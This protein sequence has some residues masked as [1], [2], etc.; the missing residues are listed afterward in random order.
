MMLS[1]KAIRGLYSVFS[2]ALI[3]L[4]ALGC[5]SA[6]QGD[7]LRSVQA[8]E[9]MGVEACPEGYNII[10]GTEGDDVIEGT[11]KP[12]CIVAYGGDD[13]IMAGNGCDI[14]YAGAGNDWI[15]TGNGNDVVYA[16]EGDDV[17]VM[18]NGDD[19]AYG[20]EGNDVIEGGNG[21]DDLSG[22]DGHDVIVGGKGS[23]AEDGGAGFD[24]CEGE[25]CD[26]DGS[27]AGACAVDADCDGGW[28][29]LPGGLCVPPDGRDSNGVNIC[30]GADDDLDGAVDEDY[31]PETTSCEVGGCLANGAMQCVDGVEVDSCLT[32]PVCYAETD[33]S[34][35]SDNDG[36]GDADCDDADCAEAPEC[37]VAEV[38][39]GD[40]CET[41]ADCSAIGPNAACITESGYGFVDGYCTAVC[42]E[43]SCCPEG[44]ILVD[45]LCAVPCTS[46]GTC[47]DDRLTCHQWA[48]GME[49]CLSAC[50]DCSDCDSN[51][52]QY[53]PRKPYG[54][55]GG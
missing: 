26:D 48:P 24:S 30:N 5:L 14:V 37:Q 47:E 49:F 38:A 9:G 19:E 22:D 13:V 55:C 54:L 32:D 33:C 29:I 11:N 44:T 35:G 1:N 18:G 6:E 39:V 34:D 16:G 27:G 2:T 21:S 43:E 52:C 25:G 20:G 53:F 51:N 31:F 8:L 15:D 46:E 28:C 12:D 17:I 50:Y 40:P 10:E 42:F 4:F 3:A 7:N 36:D 23:D 45:V 41:D